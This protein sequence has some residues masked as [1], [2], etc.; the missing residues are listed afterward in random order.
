M[1]IKLDHLIEKIKQEGIDEAQQTSDNIVQQAKQQARS[2]VEQARQ[3]ADEI[4][5]TARAQAAALRENAEQDL[6]QAAR[7]IE[8][9]LK[10]RI[11][12][13]FDRAFQREV[14]E[15]LSPDILKALILKVADGWTGD[16]RIEIMLS[17]VDHENLQAVLFA[18]LRA[19]L[20]NAVTLRASNRVSKGFRIGLKGEHAYYDFS[21][22]AIAETL[23]VFL[24]PVLNT[25]LNK[26]EDG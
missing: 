23:Q 24:S 18:G 8:L 12:D 15:A 11:V 2:I 21:D 4:L 7:D 13:L 20:R 9:L 19:E 5:K 16:A 14:S 10:E 3:E 26:G 22:S 1:E 25:I 17:E 6:R